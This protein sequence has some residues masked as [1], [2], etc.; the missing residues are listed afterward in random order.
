MKLF[1][2]FS[3][4]GYHSSIITTFGIDFD[5]Y[6]A[7]A[8]PRLRD[9]GCHN[10]ILLADARMLVQALGDSAHRPKFAGRR[11]SV[12]GAQCAGVFHPKLILQ[13]GKASGR[14]LVTSANMTAA[15]MA[16][17]FEIAG[18]VVVADGAMEAAPLLR[19]AV[20]YLLRFLAPASVARRQI[21]WALKRSRWLPPS[22]P[23][24]VVA[25][26]DGMR[27]AFL[28]KNDGAGVAERF[29]A[30]VG[31]RVVTRVVVISPYWDHDLRS[32]RGLRGRLGAARTA[33][34]IQPQSAL[35]PVHAHASAGSI[36]LFDVNRVPGAASRFAHAKLVIA[37]ADSGDSVL[38]GSANCTEAALGTSDE[39][40]INEEAC[41]AR[42]LPAGEAVRLL[43]LEETLSAG[44]ELA[45]SSVP[46]F[47]PTEDIP[48]LDLAARLPG[49]FELL[50]GSCPGKWCRKLL[51]SSSVLPLGLLPTFRPAPAPP[52]T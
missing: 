15:G 41:L 50:G 27:V 38:F 32:L 40:G 29:F 28:A 46:S 23:E 8:L 10:N 14:L 42:D 17:N 4:S 6:E 20:D 26:Q 34:L 51:S 21:E 48:L 9:A 1:N 3:G 7:I 13:L 22:A 30:F 19:A 52:A 5:A 44:A 18:E 37:E 45:I 12:V 16:G 11:Y 2:C 39:A 25:L 35:Y 24:A 31:D 47:S 36:D 43:G 33:A 49:R